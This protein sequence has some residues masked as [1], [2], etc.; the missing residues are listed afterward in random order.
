MKSSSVSGR[1]MR[2]S[3]QERQ[4]IPLPGDMPDAAQRLVVSEVDRR[5]G[6]AGP[7][8]TEAPGDDQSI[9]ASPQTEVA[10]GQ[11]IDDD[12]QRDEPGRRENILDHCRT[13]NRHAAGCV[14]SRK[15]LSSEAEGSNPPAAPTS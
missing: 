7:S 9:I 2:F 5:H 13:P 10:S 12:E 8:R 1:P 6:L 14:R 3:R 4:S 15:G 11:S